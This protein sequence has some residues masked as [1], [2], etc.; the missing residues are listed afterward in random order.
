MRICVLHSSYEL[1]SS[2]LKDKDPEC[3]P[4]RFLPEHEW[5]NAYLHKATAVRQIGDLRRQGFDVFVNLC[6]GIEIFSVLAD[7]TVVGSWYN[8]D[9][10]GAKAP[11]LGGYSGKNVSPRL[12][13]VAADPDADLANWNFNFNVD[14]RTFDLWVHGTD[15]SLNQIE[16]DQP[17]S[18]TP[19][20]CFF[21]PE[22]ERLPASTRVGD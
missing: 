8:H 19:G 22:K 12:S 4:S 6:D 2:V 13:W 17:Y 18:V 11:M 20:A 1:S 15:F 5:H 7:K 3:D 10:A 14:A 9:C 21:G 16:D